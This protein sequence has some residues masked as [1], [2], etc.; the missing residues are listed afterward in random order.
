MGIAWI[1][2]LFSK[3]KPA[4]LDFKS[5]YNKLSNVNQYHSLPLSVKL[6]FNVLYFKAVKL[7]V[8]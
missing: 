2:I 3:I 8:I 7:G 4:I 1:R 5:A 6:L